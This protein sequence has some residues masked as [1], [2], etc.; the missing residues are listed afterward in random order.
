MLGFDATGRL[1]LGQLPGGAAAVFNQAVNATATGSVIVRKSV[2]KFVRATGSGAATARKAIAHTR[3]VSTT[4]AV[5]VRKSV[6]KFVRATGAGTVTIA[7]PIIR[8]CIV[9]VTAVSSVTMVRSVGKIAA[10]S[11]HGAVSIVRHI[12]FTLRVSTL[13]NVTITA[14]GLIVQSVRRALYLRGRTGSFWKGRR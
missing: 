5:V 10:V 7:R 8:A 4:G 12:A 9:L 3:S 2:G 13:G 11:A 1:A 14:L 6:G